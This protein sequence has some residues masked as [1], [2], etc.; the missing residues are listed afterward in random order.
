MWTQILTREKKS[1]SPVNWTFSQANDILYIWM[2]MKQSSCLRHST[3]NMRGLDDWKPSSAYMNDLFSCWN[4]TCHIKI[5][6]K[7][8]LCAWIPHFHTFSNAFGCFQ[9]WT[10][11][12]AYENTA[13]SD[14][15]RTFSIRDCPRKRFI[16]SSTLTGLFSCEL[17]FP[18]CE[19]IWLNLQGH[20][21]GYQKAIN[22]EKKTKKKTSKTQSN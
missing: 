12:L 5:F 7:M 18:R 10:I 22:D 21:S 16:F 9:A 14:V 4:E 3:Y 19:N 8:L 1:M 13:T 11:I 6:I 17:K 2:W 20:R 15:N